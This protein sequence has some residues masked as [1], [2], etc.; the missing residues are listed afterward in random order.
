MAQSLGGGG[1]GGG[2]TVTSVATG[3]G[4][5]GGPITSSG[6][7]SVDV[8]TT[9]NKIVQ[10]NGTGQLPAVDGSQLTSVDASKIRGTSVQ[11]GL[12]PATGDFLKYVGSNWTTG[13]VHLSELKSLI[14]GGPLF[15]ATPCT[16]NQTLQYVSATDTF[17][18]VDIN[19]PSGA[20][21][22]T[23][24]GS[25]TVP[26]GVKKIKATVIGAGGGG[27]TSMGNGAN[28]AAGFSVVNKLTPGDAINITVGAGGVQGNPSGTNGADSSFG[29]YVVAP[30]G[31]GCSSGTTPADPNYPSAPPTSPNFIYHVAL[32]SIKQTYLCG[33]G[34]G[35]GSNGQNGC[36]L[37]EW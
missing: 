37:L 1:G 28:G 32:P 5:T 9:A 21:L 4:L 10:L 31:D 20:Q 3:T 30:G 33:Y 26:V 22:F 25:F 19:I 7:L 11:A 8:G 23:T 27:C 13:A 34:G 17:D 15:S 14:G 29:T 2:G 24:N 35:M 18:C 16:T 36:V 12:T 6:T